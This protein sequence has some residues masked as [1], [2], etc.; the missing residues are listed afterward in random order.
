MSLF[1]NR[2]AIGYMAAGAALTVAGAAVIS[3]A[4][5]KDPAVKTS[6]ARGVKAQTPADPEA[7]QP[8]Q[9]FPGG[10]GGQGPFGGQG[11][12]GGF[13][14]G[15]PGGQG[16]RGPMMGMMGAPAT[17][18]ATDRYVFILRGDTLYQYSTDGLKLV[19]KAELPRDQR[20]PRGGQGGPGGPGGPG[21]PP[22][23]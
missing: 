19:G 22:Q 20:G 23:R 5:A 17:M 14:G 7:P 6:A 21:E 18:T 11:G 4:Q 3:T 13:P 10:G 12:P 8:P 9:G 2:M 15:G 16:M 1:S